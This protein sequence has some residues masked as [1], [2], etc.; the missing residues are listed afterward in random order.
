MP[1]YRLDLGYDGTGFHG[2]ASQRGM[3]TVQGEL[4]EALSKVFR[5]P[6]SL[7]AAGRTDAGVHARHQ[8]VSFSADRSVDLPQVVRAVTSML[9]PEIVAT[10]ADLVD[11]GFSARFSDEPS[12]C[13]LR[14]RA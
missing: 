6:I 3:R 11:E 8:V 12:R 2:F 1:H 4:E 9:G 14:R 5:E 13:P 10:Q 7:V